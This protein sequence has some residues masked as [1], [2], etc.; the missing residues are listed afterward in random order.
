MKLGLN[1]AR[2]GKSRASKDLRFKSSSTKTK[3][4]N[5]AAGINER[6]EALAV[7]PCSRLAPQLGHLLIMFCFMDEIAKSATVYWL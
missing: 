1:R 4:L 3:R 7:N 6:P 2:E 5:F